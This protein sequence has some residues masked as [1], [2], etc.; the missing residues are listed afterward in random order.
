MVRRIVA[1]QVFAP[2]AE[3]ASKDPKSVGGRRPSSRCV[4]HPHQ[5]PGMVVVFSTGALLGVAR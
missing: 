1:T 5:N 3:Y 2:A 4:Q